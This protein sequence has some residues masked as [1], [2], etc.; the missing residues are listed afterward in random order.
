MKNV[1]LCVD[2]VIE[3][4]VVTTKKLKHL[5]V[6]HFG[7]IVNKY[8]ELLTQCNC[9]TMSN[10]SLTVSPQIEQKDDCCQNGQNIKRHPTEF[11]IQIFE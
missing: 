9:S 1:K 5:Q 11:Q 3:V 6:N 10:Y 8:N 4:V 7:L 2:D